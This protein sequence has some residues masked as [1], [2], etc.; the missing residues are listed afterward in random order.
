MDEIWKPIPNT[1]YSVS[2]QGR[3]ASRK[4][5]KWRVMKF[6]VLRAGYRRLHVCSNGEQRF[7]SVHVLVAEA[8]IGP[9]TS[10]K[11]EVNH[12]DGVRD[13]NRAE[14]LEWVT[15]G[16]NMR[17]RR[18]VL[19]HGWLRGADNGFAKLTESDIRDIRARCL[20]GET[21]QSVA[22]HY[23]L[24][25]KYVSRIACGK[26][27]GWLDPGATR[28]K[29]IIAS[30]KLTEMDVREIRRRCAAGELQRIV[31]ADYGIAQTNVSLIVLRERWAWVA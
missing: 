4:W 15:R 30:T 3:V 19:K 12:I 25:W 10:P 13:N 16:E 9:R 21:N 20:A 6:G 28:G 2:D 14:N 1:D 26:S 29:R 23:G 18:D 24:N 7:L 5:G 8:F 17:H 22:A 31:A 27:W 11:H